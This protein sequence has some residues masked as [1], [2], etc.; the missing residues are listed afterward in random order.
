VHSEIAAVS[1]T[2]W[3]SNLL[4]D[5]VISEIRERVDMVTLVGEYVHLVKRGSNHV[6]LCPFHAEKTPSFNVSAANKFFHCFGCKES[7]D[8]FAFVMHVEGVA[9][10]QAARLLAERTGVEIPTSDRAEDAAERRARAQRE[11]LHA[12]MEEACAFYE[13]QLALHPSAQ[14]ARAELERRGI[15]PA[16]AARFRIGY[17]PHAW[18]ALSSHLAGKQH[19][20]ADAQSVGLVVPR[21]DGSGHY[22]RFRGRLM[23]PIREL[24]G[25]VLAFSGRILA[26]SDETAAPSSSASDPGS[27]P[28]EPKYVNSPEGPLYNKGSVLY[29]LHEARVEVR[30]HGWALLCEGNFDLLALHQA[31]FGNALAPMGTAFTAAQAK[32][33]GRFAQ[34]VTLLFDGDA[35]GSKAVRAAFPLLQQQGLRALV[36]QLPTGQ[37]PDSYLRAHGREGLDRLLAGAQGIVEHLID[38]AA[39]Q[40]GSSAAERAAV[41]ETLVP[42]LRAVSSAVEMELLVERVAQRLG[43]ADTSSVRRQLQRGTGQDRPASAASTPPN[44]ALAQTPDYVRLPRLQTELLGVLLDRPALFATQYATQLEGLLTSPELLGVLRAA[45]VT[46]QE[47]GAL[48]LSALFS[49]LED[50]PA[51]PWLRERLAL[52]L[53]RDRGDAEQVLENGIPLLAKRNLERELPR[54]GQEISKA[55]RSG[56]DERAV[57]LTKQRDELRRSAHGLLRRER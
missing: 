43:L 20:L 47:S 27:R 39:E 30:R 18:D 33:L 38:T 19:A 7:G 45:A 50:S 21:R 31:G 9:F 5:E 23:F 53:Y 25:Q 52:Q 55:R 26:L 42:V 8:A 49:A 22:D 56:D 48:D 24:S 16:T 36:A 51:L 37:D 6:G 35:A 34:R 4:S 11:R 14:V 29:G 54:L 46:V 15:L 17:A 40:A 12:V 32:L 1:S 13:K 57:L 3:A 41:V 10:P 2:L 28:E 44:S